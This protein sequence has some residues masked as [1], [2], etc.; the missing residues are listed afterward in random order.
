MVPAISASHVR[1][2]LTLQLRENV[3]VLNVENIN[4]IQTCIVYDNVLLFITIR[5][6]EFYLAFPWS[7]LDLFR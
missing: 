7:L 2:V 4:F 3:I 1:N 5:H 6:L